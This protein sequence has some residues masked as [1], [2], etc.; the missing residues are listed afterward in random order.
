MTKEELLI[1][2][3][4]LKVENELLKTQLSKA[5]NQSNHSANGNSFSSL[6]QLTSYTINNTSDLICWINQKAEVVYVNEALCKQ[7]GYLRTSALGIKITDLDQ[8]FQPDNWLYFWQNLKIKTKITYESAIRNKKGEFLPV[9]ITANFFIFEGTEYNCAYIKIITERKEAQRKLKAQEYREKALIKAIP[10]SIFLMNDKGL[11]LDARGGK[12]MSQYI[13]DESVIGK[14]IYDIDIPSE[15]AEMIIN[16]NKKAI[17]TGEVQAI[18]YSLTLADGS[19]RYYESRAVRYAPNLAF[20]IVRD[21]TEK[22]V[23]E[24]K[25]RIEEERKNT[26]L[27]TI[28][29]VIFLMNKKG[30][31]LEIRGGGN[32]GFLPSGQVIGKNIEEVMPKRLIPELLEA[33]HRALET[34]NVQIVEYFLKYADSSMHYF[35]SRAVRF[36]QDL[37]LRIVR[38]ITERKLAE[39]KIK[40]QDASRR[41]IIQA[42]PDIIVVM[43]EHGD[44]LDYRDGRGRMFVNADTII[45]SNISDSKMPQ[46]IIN[47]ILHSNKKALETGEV[48]TVEY[49]LLFADTTKHYY[50]SRAIK[51]NE[52]LILRIIREITD[53]KMIEIENQLLLQETQILNEELQASEEEIRQTL[54]HTLE[55]KEDIERRKELYKAMVNS[56]PDIIV[57]IDKDYNIEFIHLP[58]IYGIDYTQFVGKQAISLMSYKER[59]LAQKK[60][61]LV[62]KKGETIQYEIFTKN[63]IGKPAY[64]ITHLSPI[65]DTQGKIEAVYSVSR[66]ITALKE[67][68]EK[69]QQT[70]VELIKQNKQLNDY[71][72]IVSHSLRAPVASILGLVDIFDKGYLKQEEIPKFVEYLKKSSKSLD[73][74]LHNLNE[75]LD[76]SKTANTIKET[77]DLQ[78]KIDLIKIQLHEQISST[79]AMIE[80]DF[81]EVSEIFAVEGVVLNILQKLISNAIKFRKPNDNPYIKIKSQKID[82]YVCISVADNGLGIDLKAHGDKIFQLYKRFHE[83]VEGRGLGLYLVRTQL[84]MFGGKIE[85]ESEVGEGSVFKIYIKYT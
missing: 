80:T 6:E 30:D 13:V 35:E 24:E 18:E 23:A 52:T 42:I 57:K 36:G 67:A 79:N 49:E 46:E 37:V 59:E 81:S 63:P 4:R 41:A 85:V 64:F 53:S 8:T 7:L 43:N 9:E 17:E 11:Y 66:D 60:L 38:E 22:K 55:L 51:Y 1:E 77:L 84:E 32:F 83:H 44:Y 15:I 78:K 62:F 26:L 40:Q 21:I 39:E 16:H 65:R 25:I 82:D 69:L 45:G 58:S 47:L 5:Q 12:D 14:N 34:G 10:D 70:N 20:R 27:N 75:L 72:F 73:T 54:D 2:I 56:S 61:E 76:D 19:Q 31:Y 71:S 50:E 28:P 48:Q 3:K 68:S 33:N 29:D 74:I